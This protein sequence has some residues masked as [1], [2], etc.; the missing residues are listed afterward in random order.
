MKR[1]V[2]VVIPIVV[3]AGL[4][5]VWFFTRS[6]S[7]PGAGQSYELTT[8]SR[9]SI[10]S[11]VSTSGTLSPISEV[12]VLSQMSG[13]VEKVNVD[14]NDRVKKGQ[15]LAEINTD[16]LKLQE[17]QSEAAVR[18][19]QANYDLYKLAYDNA[20]ILYQKGLLSEYDFK[21]S[22]TNLN[23]Y[24]ADL[25]TAQTA[26]KVIQ[27]ELNQYALVTAPI[28]GIVINKNIDVG[29]SVLEGSSSNA[30]SLFTLS[31]DLSRMQIK[32]EVD[33]LDISSIKVGQAVRFTVEA[34]P[35]TTYDGTVSQI[36]L[37][38]ETSNNVVTY[39]VIINAP[40]KDGSL[41]PGMTANVQFIRE[42]KTDVVM[43]PAAAFRFQPTTLGAAQ[44]AKLEFLAGLDGLSAEEQ[45]TA[46]KAYD[47][48]VARA[49]Q[50]ADPA[51]QK[52]GGLAGMMMPGPPRRS[53]SSASMATQPQGSPGVSKKPLWYVGSDGKLGVYMV[54]VGAT[55]GKNTEIVGADALLGKAVILKVKVG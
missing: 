33:E 52:A 29:Q 55:D 12:S 4:A 27:T 41:L 38:P 53:T 7:T 9:G 46:E 49:A 30:T 8:V 1:A 11:V 2:L 45:A 37:V 6:K 28:T 51:P 25:A 17:M 34:S 36:R 39:D 13:T 35:G 31:E 10:E 20:A 43:V 18:K 19:A 40:N 22:Q 23:L 14:Y 54:Q 32:A 47:E 21:S 48:Q 5:G 15:V 16:M 50:A 44:I 42:R 26:L 3:I 24:T